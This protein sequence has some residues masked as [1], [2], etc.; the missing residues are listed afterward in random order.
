MPEGQGKDIKGANEKIEFTGYESGHSETV[1]STPLSKEEAK[2]KQKQAQEKGKVEDYI[3]NDANKGAIAKH[4]GQKATWAGGLAVGLQGARIVGRR[5]WNWTTGKE[6][7]SVE[8]DVK[9]FAESSI[10]SGASVGK[11]LVST[12]TYLYGR[13]NS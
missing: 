11:M 12:R 4:I 2:A 9:E 1:E 7:Q 8:D 6:N 10:K 13:R 5:L 3:W